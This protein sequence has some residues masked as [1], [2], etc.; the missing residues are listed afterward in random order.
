MRPHV[1][2]M[3]I[4]LIGAG[5]VWAQ[6]A[7]AEPDRNPAPTTNPPRGVRQYVEEQT[8]VIELKSQIP[9]VDVFQDKS[10]TYQ[11]AGDYGFSFNLES[12]KENSDILINKWL[13]ESK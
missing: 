7:P 12:L 6:Q 4:L 11:K 13:K 3:L 1:I 9:D 8:L 2:L 10:D 5:I